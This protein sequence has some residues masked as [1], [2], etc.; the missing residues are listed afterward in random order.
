LSVEIKNMIWT[1]IRNSL[2]NLNVLTKNGVE[3]GFIEKPR[4][5]KTDTNAWRSFVGIGERA[6]F[7]GH[8]WTK[9]AAKNKVEE[10]FK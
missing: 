3:V 1:P 10:K 6:A 5:T 9:K 4:D 7:V 8:S 2:P